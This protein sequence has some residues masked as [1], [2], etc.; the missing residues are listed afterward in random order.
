MGKYI[1][2]F[3]KVFIITGLFSILLIILDLLFKIS[4]KNTN[5]LYI[6][7]TSLMIIL[8]VISLYLFFI[9]SDIKKDQFVCLKRLNYFGFIV[10][11]LVSGYWFF[12]YNNPRDAIV[13]FVIY[14]YIFAF[15]NLIIMTII[16]LIKRTEGKYFFKNWL[17]FF[18]LIAFCI[19]YVIIM[20]CVQ[21][22]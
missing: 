18:G 2:F 13:Y 1:C 14:F 22:T 4:V 10:L 9:F 3:R 6:A 11:L 16:Y 15:A 17:N 21:K 5:G 7:F 19:L 12:N 20:K 8:F